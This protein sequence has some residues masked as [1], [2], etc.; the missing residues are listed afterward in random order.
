MPHPHQSRR[1]ITDGLQWRRR[2]NQLL[3]LVRHE[4]SLPIFTLRVG[5]EAGPIALE[6]R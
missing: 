6:L 1:F 5:R 4:S 3:A 2:F